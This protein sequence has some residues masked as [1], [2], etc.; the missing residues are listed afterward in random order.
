M[1]PKNAAAPTRLRALFDELIDLDPGERAA[2]FARLDPNDPDIV[3]LEDL[4][5]AADQAPRRLAGLEF[6]RGVGPSRGVQSN[7]DAAAAFAPTYAIEGEL[8]GGGMSRVFF[9]RDAKLGR[10]IV[11]KVLPPELAAEVN[12]ER[13]Q[14]EIR[15]AAQLRH[16]H[17][18]PLLESGE[19]GGCLYYTMPLIEGE[20]LRDRLTRDGPLP[21][22][23]AL[24]YAI[25]IADA[26]A[27]AHDHGV[28]HRDIKPGNVL[29]DAGHAV[30]TDFGIAR[31]LSHAESATL[32]HSGVV[33]GTPAYMS[34]EQASSGAVDVRTDIYSLGCV[35]HEMLYGSPP[36]GRVI[37]FA[38]AE[39]SGG[40]RVP[41]RVRAIIARAVAPRSA[42]RFPSAH[43]MRE[44]LFAA[45]APRLSPRAIW[46]TVAAVV[47]LVIATGLALR[48]RT[49]HSFASPQAV[50]KQVTTRGDVRLA[51]I[52]PGGEYFAF[53][54]GDTILRVGEVGTGAQNIIRTGFRVGP[55]RQWLMHQVSWSPD[56]SMLY[57]S[58]LPPDVLSVIPKV[59]SWRMVIANP[60]LAG[61]VREVWNGRPTA[62]AF[63]ISPFDSSLALSLMPIAWRNRLGGPI[64]Q[65]PGAIL[66]LPQ[67]G[68]G[69]PDTIAVRGA[70]LWVAISFSPN[71]RWLAACGPSE[72]RPQKWRLAVLAVDGT[73]QTM[74]DSSGGT[75]ASC[76]V[77]W[78]SRGDSLYAWPNLPGTEMVSYRIDDRTGKVV[79]PPT[80][81]RLPS[82]AA[83]ERTDFSLSADGRRLAFIQHTARRYVAVAELGAGIEVRSQDVSVGAR[84]PSRPEISPAGDRFAYVIADDSGSAI[85]TQDV[86]GGEPRRLSR[87]YRAGVSGVRWSDDGA[88]LATLTRRDSQPVILIL[89]ATGAEVMTVRMRHTIYDTTVFRPSYDWAAHSTGIVYL[90]NDSALTNLDT[91]LIDLASGQERR[92]LTV[93]DGAHSIYPSL[94]VWSPDGKSF[95]SNSSL[96]VNIRDAAT[97]TKHSLNATGVP[98][99]WRADETFFSER[100]NPDSST[101]IWR[102][103]LTEPPT[104]YAHLGKEC[105]LI[106]MDREARRAVCEVNRR[107]S[108]VFVVTRP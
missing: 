56:G 71:G 18:V 62:L 7:F 104:L 26:L 67:Q 88:R 64:T 108:D 93:R 43:A 36:F 15:I 35:L 16:P 31:A 20:S 29:I 92:L 103:T 72:S 23:V 80:P 83:G 30:V 8:N 42:D 4:L 41:A 85:Y 95:L 99:L 76:G 102:S 22:S 100:I 97:G 78:G 38:P 81:F 51:A 90:A 2:R 45:A 55:P 106:S 47:L 77:M 52:S 68:S 39:R 17:I 6:L 50:V 10:K 40:V 5:N 34:P 44:A 13:F 66:H 21:V 65:E 86:S 70:Q 48:P 25:D 59:G 27:Y 91:W 73:S 1:S 107:E 75:R 101:S 33:M 11:A 37:A 12:L 60:L 79:G 3:R 61:P 32:T 63:A 53:L 96:D 28:I 9:G 54:T 87:H 46:S 58:P 105:K 89:D 84:D 74:L 57:Y 69:R 94:P 49:D 19:A 24:R 98:L 82:G 14:H